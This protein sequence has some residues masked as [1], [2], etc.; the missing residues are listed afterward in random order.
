[1]INLWKIG[2]LKLNILR[3]NIICHDWLDFKIQ[4]LLVINIP[5]K[6]NDI[7]VVIPII[8]VYA[9]CDL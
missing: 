3:N 7:H 6:P 5:N 1:M 4:S 2:K 9:E 8:L